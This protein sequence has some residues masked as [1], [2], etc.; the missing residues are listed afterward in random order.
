MTS[1]L[2]FAIDNEAAMLAFGQSLSKS[3]D[4]GI[5]IYLNG[6]LGAGK[7]TLVRGFLRG[8]GFEGIVKS[9]TYTLVEPYQFSS[10]SIFHFDLYRLQDPQELLDIGIQDYFQQNAICLI[11][12]P[13]Q[14]RPFLTEADISCEIMVVDKDHRKMICQAFSEKGQG[15]LNRLLNQ[16][17]SPTNLSQ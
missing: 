13:E 10:Q 17:L 11:E 12:W 7:T 9:P 5:V 16:G 4:C 3:C 15:M 8:F 2:R 6:E 14:G 1:G